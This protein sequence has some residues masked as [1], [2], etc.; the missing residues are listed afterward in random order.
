MR[1][2]TQSTAKLRGKSIQFLPFSCYPC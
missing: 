1:N 2:K